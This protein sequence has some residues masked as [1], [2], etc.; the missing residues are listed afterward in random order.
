MSKMIDMR[1]QRYN[2]L[3]AIEPDFSRKSSNL[4]W[5]FQCDCGKKVS[6]VGKNVRKGITT[7]C[8]C[9]KQRNWLNSKIGL[10]TVIE[11]TPERKNRAVVWK[12]RCDCGNIVY[13]NSHDLHRQSVISCG[14]Q[15]ISLGESIIEKLLIDN[16][17]SYIREHKF[18]NCRFL[19]TNMCARF[20]FFVNN[21]YLIEFDGIGHYKQIDFF[22]NKE[23][24]QKQI[25]FDL[26]KNNWCN[27]MGLPLI[28]IPYWHLNDLDIK[29]LQLETTT[30]LI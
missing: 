8:G 30:F 23:D 5:W 9:A 16:N 14:C 10:L 13:V 25:E 20:D 21:E 6:I 11:R 27:Q 1:G 12:C 24:Y 15:K 7:S 18:D 2:S 4:Y 19:D 22:G 17:I 26:F 3:V 29:D 28:R